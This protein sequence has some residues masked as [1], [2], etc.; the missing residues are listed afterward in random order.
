MIEARR[1]TPL[2]F[3]AGLVL[4]TSCTRAESSP[5]RVAHSQA[6]PALDGR[7]LTVSML[8]VTYPPGGSS[9]PHA[10]GCPVVGYVLDGAV[11]M[12]VKG[13]QPA[14]Y[15]PGE[16]FYEAPGSMH[17]VSANASRELPARFL[18]WFI[19][20]GNAPRSVALSDSLTPEDFE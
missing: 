6:L 12:Q 5:V 20:E 4:A 2:A 9:A 7:A 19:C 15:R 8:E 14:V 3:V 18:T 10:H 11:R 13:H 16:T 1:L 17:L